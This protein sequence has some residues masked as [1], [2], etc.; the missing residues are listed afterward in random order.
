MSDTLSVATSMYADRVKHVSRGMDSYDLDLAGAALLYPLPGETLFSLCSRQHRIWGR[1]NARETCVLLFGGE[2]LGT[3]HDIPSGPRQLECRTKGQWGG[4][5]TLATRRT[6]MRFYAPFVDRQLFD[7]ANESMHGP[8]VAH[9]KFRLGPLT[10]RFRANHPLEACRV[11]T[12]QDH[13]DHGWAYWHL[14]H[15]YPGVWLCPMHEV[16]RPGNRGGWLV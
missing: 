10:S 12:E 1:P 3:Q 5:S 6:L 4:A 11:C 7:G 13:H 14:H 9:L 16:N 2:R 15:Q 8:S